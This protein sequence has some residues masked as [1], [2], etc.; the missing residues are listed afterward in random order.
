MPR[1]KRIRGPKPIPISRIQITELRDGLGQLSYFIF[2]LAKRFRKHQRDFVAVPRDN[3]HGF[4]IVKLT[5]SREIIVQPYCIKSLYAQV[6]ELTE[7]LGV[8]RH[9]I[10]WLNQ[11]PLNQKNLRLEHFLTEKAEKEYRELMA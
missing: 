10:R 6:V 9:R 1:A 8:P 7:G 4:L 5:A 11:I 2:P 3:P